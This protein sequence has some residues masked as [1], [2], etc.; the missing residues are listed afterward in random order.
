MLRIL[1]HPTSSLHG[2]SACPHQLELRRHY[3]YLPTSFAELQLRL[4]SFQQRTIPVRIRMRAARDR[5]QVR[6]KENAGRLQ[7]SAREQ[8]AGFRGRAR[9]RVGQFQ[10]DAQEHVA[11]V[12]DRL[13]NQAQEG[14]GMARTRAV[15]Y[16]RKQRA[17]MREH[18]QQAASRRK[19]RL[20]ASIKLVKD[21]F[22]NRL[23]SRSDAVRQRLRSRTSRIRSD[24]QSI[25][26]RTKARY[27]G[28]VVLKRV[29]LNEYSEADW[30]DVMGRPLTSRDT[31]GRFVNPWRSQSTNGVHG[32]VAILKWR[33]ERLKREYAIFGWKVALPSYWK[34]RPVETL[35]SMASVASLSGLQPVGR[36]A[37]LDPV[38]TNE[39]HVTW[40]GHA[41]CLVRQGDLRILTDP[42]FSDRAS[43]YQNTPVGIARDVPPVY[44]AKDLP[45]IDLCLISHDHYDHLDRDSVLQLKDKVGKWIVPTGVGDFLQEGCDI[46]RRSIVEL[47]WWESVKLH[48]KKNGPWKAVQF[49]SVGDTPV[50]PARVTPSTPEH[51]WLTCCPAQHWASRTFFDRNFRLWCSFCVF[52]PRG[53]FYF[54]GD[55][56][57]PP[58][59]P[60][61]EQISEHIGPV[62][63][64]ALPIGAYEP[65]W[66]MKDSHMN[67]A[68]AVL[69]HQKLRARKSIGIHWGTFPL[70]EEPLGDPS[71]RLQREAE[72]S[73]VDFV[74][75]P[76]GAS[77]SVKCSEIEEPSSSFEWI[78]E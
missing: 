16:Y 24:L 59:F 41:T 23:E 27:G 62:D 43:P 3:L 63:L 20:Q 73:L 13:Q 76:H 18:R 5:L 64:A 66:F 45:D 52:L 2:S 14:V 21:S 58:E 44:D 67:P 29:T 17:S 33:W 40:L 1:R 75:V 57:L 10:H 30:F 22:R 54:G 46:P 11:R 48:R 78:V 56:A 38:S 15:T 9:D 53:T 74:T 55:S 70:S 39:V 50:H 49:T 32:L 4:Q 69:V 8:M 12:V 47:E 28:K 71:L 37:L 60:L 72:K 61:F 19:L 26:D 36:E 68:E 35:K 51:V 6:A 25:W 34:G 7:V 65:D 31:T 77:V 42:I